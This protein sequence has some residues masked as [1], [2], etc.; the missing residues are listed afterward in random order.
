ME[1]FLP[2]SPVFTP[3]YTIERDKPMPS[4]NHAIIQAN[5]SFLLTLHYRDQYRIMSE[6]SLDMPGKGAVPD[7]A[8]YPALPYDSLH[9]EISMTQMPLGVIEIMS[10]SQTQDE[11]VEKAG[12]YFAAGVLSYWL[13][14]PIFKIVHILHGANEY[15]NFMSGTLID[16]KIG[17]SLEVSELFR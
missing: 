7:I 3:A 11:L 14:N 16:E 17:V 13:I 12:R 9:D 4:K 8:I 5:L 15:Q 1:A 10:P 6:I 2:Q